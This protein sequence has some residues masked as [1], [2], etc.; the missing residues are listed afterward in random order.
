MRKGRTKATSPEG[1]NPPEM[2]SAT[3]EA[4]ST[5][6]S[7]SRGANGL[8]GAPAL[9]TSSQPRESPTRESNKEGGPHGGGS[10][11]ATPNNSSNVGALP[12]AGQPDEPPAREFA[13]SSGSLQL[14]EP[15]EREFA[16]SGHG[17]SAESVHMAANRSITRGTDSAAMGSNGSPNAAT[18]PRGSEPHG[19][20]ARKSPS[21]RGRLPDKTLRREPVPSGNSTSAEVATDA[22]MPQSSSSNAGSSD[23]SSTKP[24]TLLEG[25]QG[26]ATPHQSPSTAS[27]D[28]PQVGTLGAV[29]LPPSTASSTEAGAPLGPQAQH[30]LNPVLQ[31]GASKSA[32]APHVTTPTLGIGAAIPD[33]LPLSH[34]HHRHCHSC[35]NSLTVVQNHTDQAEYRDA[36]LMLLAK[37]HFVSLGC[38]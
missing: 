1:S 22:P 36:L 15:F 32:P 34:M 35:L 30:A 25:H 2:E 14:G 9:L 3:N 6:Q 37:A 19:A 11:A 7:A 12:P 29:D 31:G 26:E 13:P 28:A 17:T 38:T 27:G 24:T 8:S 33:F 16:S 23:T 21:A 5:P 4:G 10:G 18:L 20:P